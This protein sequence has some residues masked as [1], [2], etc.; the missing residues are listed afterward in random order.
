MN[1]QDSHIPEFGGGTS[2]DQLL[3]Y[4]N[5]TRM[6]GIAHDIN[7]SLTNIEDYQNDSVASKKSLSDLESTLSRMSENSNNKKKVKPTS[8]NT[9]DKEESSPVIPKMLWEPLL[10]LAIYIFLSLEFVRTF[11][12]KYIPYISPD[13]DDIGILG[14]IIYGVLIFVIF[15][16]MRAIII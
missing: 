12:G 10:F 8:E 7:R 6:A 2:V 16:L 3:Q 4:R 5:D 14:I 13:N 9:N 15:I 1:Y 11:L